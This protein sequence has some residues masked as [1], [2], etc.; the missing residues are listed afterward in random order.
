MS[1]LWEIVSLAPTDPSWINLIR[2]HPQATIFHHPAWINLLAE[3]YAFRPSILSAINQQG[4]IEAGI[5]LMIVRSLFGKRRWVSLPYTDY[6]QPLF[7]D[8]GALQPLT[9]TLINRCRAEKNLTIE[10]RWE[11]PGQSPIQTDSH[12]ILSKL[13][14]QS[15]EVE[16]ARRINPKHFRQI[17]VAYQRGVRIERGEDLSHLQ[18]FYNLHVQTRHRKGIPVQPWSFFES[19]WEKIIKEK[20]GFILL[21]YKDRS[22]VAGAIFLHWNRT[23]TYKYSASV[24]EARHLLAMDPLIWTAICWGCENNYAVLDMGRTEA[25]DVGLRHF[26]S[27]WGAIEEKLFYSTLSLTPI[28]SDDRKLMGIMQPVIR[29]S[30]LWVCKLAGEILYR[31]FG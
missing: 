28:H 30:P 1:R 25:E 23:L 29:K 13:S 14:L 16:I 8:A 18:K 22:C 10:L 12:Y 15:G 27:R 31:Y 7:T 19:L 17:K 3:N 4:E 20:M 5:P 21:A 24:E 9:E 26:K 11:Y 2:A 6:C